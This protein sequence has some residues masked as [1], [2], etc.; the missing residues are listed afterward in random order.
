MIPG[1]G[2][3]Q[4]RT[5]RFDLEGVFHAAGLEQRIGVQAVLQAEVAV[6]LE[7][8][9]EAEGER[10]AVDGDVLILGVAVQV[11]PEFPDQNNPV[12]ALV[13][14]LTTPTASTPPGALATFN[15]VWLAA[16]IV[17]PL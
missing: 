4:C 16:E 5:I 3:G 12:T 11:V 1:Q 14:R 15:T 2:P 17:P 6:E 10:H 13:A 9:R 7:A 8:V